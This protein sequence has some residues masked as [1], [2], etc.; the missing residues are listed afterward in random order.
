MIT[1]NYTAKNSDGELVRGQI[2]AQNE[3]AAAKVLT[4]KKLYPIEISLRQDSGFAILNRVSLKDKV[5]FTRQLSA[6]L[7]AGL[8][9]TQALETISEQ[10]TSKSLKAIIV[11]IVSDVEGGMQLSASFSRFPQVF[12]RIDVALVQSGEASGTLDKVLVRLADSIEKDYMVLKK[13]KSALAYPAFILGVVA[14]VVVLMTMYVMPQM[15]TLYKDFNSELPAVTVAMLDFSHFL[16]QFGIFVLFALVAIATGLRYYVTT[17][18]GR[19]LW[20]H[21]IINTPILSPFLRSLYASRFSRTMAGLVGSGVS[22]LDSLN[23]TAGAVGNEVVS[24]ALYKCA[25][26]V[27]GGKPLSKPLRESAIFSPIVPQMISV[28]EQTG[29]MDAMFSNLADYFDDEVD[30]FVRTI[31]S[32]L[33]PFIIVLMGG[34]VAVILVAVMMPIYDIGKIF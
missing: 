14:L 16:S 26:E 30:N 20:D 24:D 17:K 11:K 32:V 4:D 3:S 29:E 31:T 34:L 25:Q 19:Y 10:T 15:E 5:L 23:I 9:I 21:L 27:K 28:G 7:S 12:N 8:P 6:T 18:S 2:E 13:V 33:E 1:F 22:L